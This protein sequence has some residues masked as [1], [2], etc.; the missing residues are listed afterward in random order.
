VEEEKKKENH[1]PMMMRP[2]QSQLSLAEEGPARLGVRVG[3]S[4]MGPSCAAVFLCFSTETAKKKK[5]I[6]FQQQKQQKQQK[7]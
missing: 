1:R 2:T 5:K 4:K 7:L 6:R 3:A